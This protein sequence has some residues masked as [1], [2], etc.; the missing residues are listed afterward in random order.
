M[1]LH[2]SWPSCD[3]FTYGDGPNL[4][5]QLSRRLASVVGWVVVAFGSIIN[6][7]AII[8]IGWCSQMLELCFNF[9]VHAS[10]FCLCDWWLS[11]WPLLATVILPWQ[12]EDVCQ[13]HASVS[14]LPFANRPTTLNPARQLWQPVSAMAL[15]ITWVGG[16][17]LHPLTTWQMAVILTAFIGGLVEYVKVTHFLP[18]CDVISHNVWNIAFSCSYITFFLLLGC[19]GSCTS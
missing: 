19:F 6:R 15:T 11:G 4:T 2:F 1:V 13:Q 16:A 10:L 3:W 5:S 8:S 14:L 12:P 9:S 17:N 7:I 18:P